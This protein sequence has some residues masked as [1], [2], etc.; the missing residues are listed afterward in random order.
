MDGWIGGQVDRCKMDRSAHVG[1]LVDWHTHER[2]PLCSFA[3][4][5]IKSNEMHE[6]KRKKVGKRM[7]QFLFVPMRYVC[8]CIESWRDGEKKD[9]RSECRFVG[10]EFRYCHWSVSI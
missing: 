4:D 9:A 2:V 8:A 7:R 5:W 6:K 10:I 3:P 1:R